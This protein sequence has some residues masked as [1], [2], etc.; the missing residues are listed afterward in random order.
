MARIP[1][2]YLFFCLASCFRLSAFYLFFGSLYFEDTPS[3]G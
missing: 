3:E 1:V 2:Q